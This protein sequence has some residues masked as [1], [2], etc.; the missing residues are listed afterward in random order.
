MVGLDSRLIDQ[1]E[2]QGRARAD[3]LRLTGEG[4][5]CCS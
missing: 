2:G 5:V 1:L 3:G 4:G